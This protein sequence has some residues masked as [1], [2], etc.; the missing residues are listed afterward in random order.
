MLRGRHDP[1]S[2]KKGGTIRVPEVAYSDKGEFYVEVRE[3]DFHVSLATIRTK[4]NTSILQRLRSANAWYENDS[5]RMNVNDTHR[6]LARLAVEEGL[7][8]SCRAG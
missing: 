4:R 6:D 5:Q 8:P 2:I 7:I 3:R 1:A